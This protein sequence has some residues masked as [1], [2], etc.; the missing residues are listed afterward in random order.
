ME[1]TATKTLTVQQFFKR[2]PTDDACLDHLMKLRHGET[3]ECAKCKKTGKSHRVRRHPAYECAWCG[4]EIFPMV[5]T[6]FHRSHTPLQKWF[7]AIYLFTTTRHGVSAKELERQLGVSYPT[8][9]RMAHLIRDYMAKV[10]GDPTL[11]GHIEADETYI[12]G[13]ATPKDKWENKFIAFGMVERGGRIRT[14]HI[15]SNSSKHLANEIEGNVEPGSTI[16]TDD[17]SGYNILQVSPYKHGTVNHTRKQ[18]VSGVHH[19]NTIEGFWSHFKRS[20]GGTHVSISGKYLT[21]YLGEFEYR[22]NNRSNPIAMLDRLLVS[23]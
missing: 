21:K 9:F 1:V 2:F 15:A 11:S 19:T 20:I 18:W 16:S 22:Y 3:I 12:G 7:Y 5:G 17:W 8:A 23:F 6:I 14:S 13:K 10:D 4:F